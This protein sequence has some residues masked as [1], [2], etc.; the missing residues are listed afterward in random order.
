MTEVD[1]GR[2]ESALA[3]RPE[4]PQ[5]LRVRIGGRE[6]LVERRGDLDTLWEAMGDDADEDRIPYWAEIWPGGVAVAEQ[7]Q[8]E[9]GRVRGKRCL[10]V[11]CGLGLTAM[12]AASLGGRVAAFDLLPE[13]LEQAAR[14]A[15]LNGIAP[16]SAPLWMAMDWRAPAVAPGSIDL[17]WGGDVV[18]EKRF[19]MPLEAMLRRALAPG[20]RVWLGEARREVSAHVWDNFRSLGWRVERLSS[21]PTTGPT[22]I[23]TVNL[24]ELRLD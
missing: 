7:M 15:A 22:S 17:A 21:R 2:A 13:A 19:F 11:G 6:W 12:V 16:E 10:D 23:M 4:A 9:P 24:W 8:R 1:S 14:N 3:D 18:Y 5:R 20:G